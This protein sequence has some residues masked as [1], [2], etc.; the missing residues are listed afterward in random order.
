[1][2]TQQL[3]HQVIDVAQ[4]MTRMGLNRGTSGNVSARLPGGFLV[5]PSGMEPER[6]HPAD[7]VAVDL[8]GECVG[9]RKPSSEWRFH[10]DLY[11]SRPEV[12]A[13]VHTHAPFCTTLAVLGRGIPAFHYMVAM[14][15]GRDIRCA[16]YAT[17]GTQ[18]LSDHALAALDGRKGCLLANHGM[19]A[20][21]RDLEDALAMA[22]E[23]ET[24]AEQY[25][26]A[27]QIGAPV[28]LPDDEMDRV[29]EKFKGYG[30]NAQQG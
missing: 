21:G 4:R 17:Y 6:L 25:W 9:R 2:S 18:E 30:R 10:R 15:G 26:R 8:D 12:G 29:I 16:A 23:L 11:R 22:V 24:L 27:L 19:L 7:I 13:V 3:R 20:V 5:T 1:M 28:L 14:L